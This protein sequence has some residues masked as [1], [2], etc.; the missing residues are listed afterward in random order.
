MIMCSD[1]KQT[2][3]GIIQLRNSE[4]VR[5]AILDTAPPGWGGPDI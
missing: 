2:G 3:A 5:V 1:T 4:E